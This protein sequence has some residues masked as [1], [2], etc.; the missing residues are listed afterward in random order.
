MSKYIP[1]TKNTAAPGGRKS[2]KMEADELTEKIKACV[3]EA[4]EEQSEAKAEGEE[5]DP[6]VEAAPGDISALIEQAMDVVAQ[7]RK[8]RKDAGEELGEV[9]TDEV[10]E[11]VGELLD[12]QEEAKADDGVEDEEAK[13]D[14]GMEGNEEKGRKAADRPSSTKAAPARKA[15]PPPPPRGVRGE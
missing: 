11:A 1:K 7:K 10:L 13:E 14:E 6:S 9:S 5:G 2:V 15:T 8:A 3:K 12:A 4:L